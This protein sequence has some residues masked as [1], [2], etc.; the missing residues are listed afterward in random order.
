MAITKNFS[1]WVLGAAAI[2]AMAIS[3][4]KPISAAVFSVPPAVI[5][6][7]C[8]YLFGVIAAQGIAIMI[9]RKVD[10]FSARNLAV[11]ATIMIIGLGG[12]YGWA[13]HMIPIFDAKLPSIATAAL[14]GIVLNLLLSIGK[15]EEIVE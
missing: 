4:I 9:N 11:I 3:F 7:A 14:F 13:D 10:M 12:Y 6:G 8:I 1:S 5:N 15:K 2:L